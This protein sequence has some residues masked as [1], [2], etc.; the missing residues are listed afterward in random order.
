[1]CLCTYNIN[2][3]YILHTHTYKKKRLYV[4]IYSCRTVLDCS[5]HVK[6]RGVLGWRHKI[7]P[8]VP[9]Q[10]LNPELFIN[11]HDSSS[12]WPASILKQNSSGCQE[13]H[14]E[15]RLPGEASVPYDWMELHWLFLQHDWVKLQ[16]RSRFIYTFF[17]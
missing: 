11:D 4:Y 13:A 10:E 3:S 5:V 7:H 12:P 2:I 14:S 6:V 16:P 1:M 9:A 17:T 15:I 8:V